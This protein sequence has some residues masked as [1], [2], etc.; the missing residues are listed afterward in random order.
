[1]DNE[2]PVNCVTFP[3]S[4][5]VELFEL[6]QQKK[7]IDVRISKLK[8]FFTLDRMQIAL[9]KLNY[10]D[11][12][13]SVLNLSDWC[14]LYSETEGRWIELEE[15]DSLYVT[16]NLKVSTH[17]VSPYNVCV[18]Q[19]NIDGSYHFY[20][21]EC[22]GLVPFEVPGELSF[23]DEERIVE[24]FKRHHAARVIQR[25]VKEWLWT[26]YYRSG[27][28]GFHARNGFQEAQDC[29]RLPSETI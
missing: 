24:N 5:F 29:L 20:T 1:M 26:P 21:D 2:L 6:L 16:L 27:H 18:V 12:L 4:T 8:G 13:E 3:M 7:Q 11:R 17:W 10:S 28:I 14:N 9:T 15:F 19:S 25:V 23:N 22:A